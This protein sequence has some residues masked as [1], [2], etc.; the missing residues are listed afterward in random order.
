[1]NRRSALAL[2]FMSWA[3]RVVSS[4]MA[5]TRGYGM[6]A[7]MWEFCAPNCRLT[8]AAGGRCFVF[9]EGRVLRNVI[10]QVRTFQPFRPLIVNSPLA[11]LVM[12][13]R[14]SLAL[15]V[16]YRIGRFRELEEWF[17]DWGLRM[18]NFL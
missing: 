7:A 8:D 9:L 14:V 6:P 4:T 17:R 1:M 16:N 2:G 18:V 10:L 12:V 5:V 11:W 15:E 3:L 13:H